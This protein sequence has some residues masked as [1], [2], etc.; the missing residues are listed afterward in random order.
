[1]MRFLILLLTLWIVPTMAQEK[2][3]VEAH[4]EP[5]SVGIGEKFDLVIDVDRDMMQVVVFP[6]FEPGGELELSANLAPDTLKQE[7]RRLRLRKRYRLQAFQEGRFN[8]GRAM[9]LYVDKNVVDTLYSEGDSLRMQVGTFQIDTT[10]QKIRD[11]K[12]QKDLPFQ[13]R[14]ISTYVWWGFL[15]LVVLGV[16]VYFLAR[17]LAKRG[18]RLKDLFKP[19]PPRPPHVVAITELEKLHNQKLY[20][21]NKHKLYYSSLTDILRTYIA[22][23]WG[24]GAMEMTSDEI[25]AEMRK[26]DLADKPSM[27]L[28]T[29]LQN[30][31]LVKFAKFA[32]DNESSEGDYLK[33]YYFVEQTKEHDEEVPV[34][35]DEILKQK[36]S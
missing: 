11:V 15:I 28:Q 9:V 13:F 14:E 16:A 24:V 32:P 5:D 34:D 10:K 4:M 1:M 25:I 8:M 35:P 19:A 18:K 21:N 31:D 3:R 12:A 29:V 2:P 36:E 33:V 22:G 27:D 20:Q 23:R 26:L 7:G 6:D 17:Y 30:A